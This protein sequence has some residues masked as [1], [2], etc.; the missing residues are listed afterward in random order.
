MKHLKKT[1]VTKRDLSMKNLARLQERL[2]NT[3]WNHITSCDDVDTAYDIFIQ[4]FTQ[5]FDAECPEKTS[6]IKTKSLLSPWMTTGLLKS[7]KRKQKLY[8]AFLKKRNFNNEKKYKAYKKSFEKTKN[9]SKRNYYTDQFQKY[10]NNIK[11]TWNV[12]KEVIGKTKITGKSLPKMMII[13]NKEIFEEEVIADEFNKYFT[14]V[15]PSL[16]SA[17]PESSSSFHSYL[18]FNAPSMTHNNL[19]TTEFNEA[20]NSLKRNKS[21]GIDQINSNILISNEKALQTPLMHICS[22]SLNTGIFPEQLKVAKITPIFKKGEKY[23]LGNYRPIS[24]LPVISKVLERI[25]YNRIYKHVT[26]NNLLYHKQFGFQKNNSTSYAIIELINQIAESFDSKKFTLGVFIDLSKAFDTVDHDIL[27]EKIKYYGIRNMPHMW[28]KNYLSNRKQYVAYNSACATRCLDITCGVPQGSILGPLLFL[29]Y[30]N[31]L[32]HATNTLETIMFADDTNLFISG[33]DIKDIFSKMNR[34]LIKINKWFCANKLSL[35][36]TKTVYTFF[37]PMQKAG[38]IPLKLPILKINN[39]IIKR[40]TFIKFLGVFIDENVTWET[41]INY[42]NEKISKN[43]GI[44]Y[45]ARKY[46]S[47]NNMKSLYFSIIHCYINYANIAWG[48]TGKSKLLKLHKHQKHISRM[49]HYQTKTTPSRNL[50]KKLKILNIFQLNIF[51]N[52]VFMYQHNINSLPRIFEKSF[53]KINHKYPTRIAKK[54]YSVPLK[55]SNSQFSF[56][57]RAPFLW[58]SILTNHLRNT[59]TLSIFKYQLKRYLLSH[60][61]ELNY[62]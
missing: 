50:M 12:I 27:L 22:L 5:I 48:S 16:A 41:H 52:L 23:I 26:E 54:H 32:Q 2:H 57:Y 39:H 56:S 7:S 8:N 34:E 24:I 36:E 18:N 53:K 28:L 58:N 60:E 3:T 61:N 45:K 44:M 10:Q 9:M 19:T 59:K 14:T 51:Q 35:N 40:E 47:F 6:Q 33:K 46:L 17:I 62:F 15:G 42:L 30:V 43:I 25:M 4:E 38:D 29:L 1:T 49:I 20:F 21:P 31:D 13:N 55:K 37:H 11:Q